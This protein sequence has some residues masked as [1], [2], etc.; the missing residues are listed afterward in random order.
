MWNRRDPDR[1]PARSSTATISPG[2]M[3]LSSADDPRS[4]T[5][6][7]SG[8][9]PTISSASGMLRNSSGT[10]RLRSTWCSPATVSHRRI[11]S[12]S[13]STFSPMLRNGL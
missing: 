2:C 9:L 8:A 1:A 11:D 3:R 6:T 5:S 10:R 12:A 4:R 7:V 13:A